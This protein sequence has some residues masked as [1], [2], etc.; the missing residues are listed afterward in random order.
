MATQTV[1][2]QGVDVAKN[3][4][5]LAKATASSEVGGGEAKYANDGI[6][7]G[8]E[9]GGIPNVLTHEWISA[10]ELAGAWLKL[11][12]DEPQ[13]ISQVVLF[14]RPNSDDQVTGGSIAFSDDSFARFGKLSNTGGPTSVTFPE[15]TIT[16]LTVNIAA[17]SKK[18][19]AIGLAE[20]AAYGPLLGVNTGAAR[21]VGRLVGRTALPAPAAATPTGKPTPWSPP[22]KRGVAVEAP[23]ARHTP[24]PENLANPFLAR[25]QGN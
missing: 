1:S 12:W 15:K 8:L 19:R 10:G 23:A 25:V 17:V 16:S 2:A 20:V 5:L 22:S 9:I 4:A 11:T 7:G 24:S 6:V 21:A 14:D 13:T 18:T 3:V